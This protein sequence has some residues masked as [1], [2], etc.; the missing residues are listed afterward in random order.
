MYNAEAHLRDCLNSL[1]NQTLDSFEVILIDD[2]SLDSSSLICDEFADLYDNIYVYHQSNHGVY[3]A[4]RAGIKAT[5][6]LSAYVTFL[7]ADDCLRN[8]ALEKI[9]R[10]LEASN[11]DILAF[12]YSRSETES[13]TRG[14]IQKGVLEP[15][16]Y[17]EKTYKAVYKAI[18]TGYFSNL[19]TKVIRKELFEGI[20]LNND[21]SRIQHGEDYLQLLPIVD[22]ARSLEFIDDVLY[23]YRENNTSESWIFRESQLLDLDYVF[24]ELKRYAVNWSSD[25]L[26]ETYKCVARNCYWLLMNVANGRFSSNKKCEYASKIKVLYFNHCPSVKLV[27]SLRADFSFPLYLALH[28]QYR[29]TFCILKCEQWLIKLLRNLE[30]RS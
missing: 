28:N 13:Y 25:A 18:C 27:F 26:K 5:S 6:D 8:D 17:T 21:T 14:C 16:I 10:S 19:C 9:S 30:I 29:A 1:V 7:D 15:G 4:R 3:V 2:G 23:F 22:K 12:N 20:S 24:K 11:A